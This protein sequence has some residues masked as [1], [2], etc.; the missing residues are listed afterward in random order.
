MSRILAI[1]WGK[2]RT[3]LATSDPLRILATPLATVETGELI[4]WLKKYFA[5]EDVGDAIIGYPLNLDGS[6]TDA[7]PGVEKFM[8]HFTRIFPHIPLQKVDERFSSRLASGALATAGR[9]K[10]L[11]ADKGLLDRT[12]ALI[13]L[14]DFL[15]A[16]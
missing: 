1:D 14:Q 6:H 12:A 10:D 3:G 11:R 13:L 5:V 2:K 9:S 4:G 16:S 8:G 7:T 15:A